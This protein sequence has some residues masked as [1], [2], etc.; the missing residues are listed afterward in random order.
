LGEYFNNADLKGKPAVTRVDQEMAPYFDK[1]APAQGMNSD[2][3]SIRWTGTITPPE[4][5]YYILGIVTDDRGRL[6]FEDK[7]K[8]DNWSPY[9]KNVMKT[10]RTKLEK[11]KE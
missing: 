1:N 9:Q 11:G 10:F 6:F 2:F 8:V 7:M 3:F 4:T 5:G